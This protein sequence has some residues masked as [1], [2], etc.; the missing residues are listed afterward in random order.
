MIIVTN[1]YLCADVMLTSYD[2]VLLKPV[3]KSR[4]SESYIKLPPKRKVVSLKV[5]EK[6][7]KPVRKK[8]LRKLPVSCPKC[9]KLFV[10]ED[11][12]ERPLRVACK[13]CDARGIIS[14]VPPPSSPP[15][16]S[17][18][19]PGEPRSTIKLSCPDCE[20]IFEV[21]SSTIENI[22]CPRCGALGNVKKPSVA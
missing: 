1:Q 14:T 17:M 10:H 2:Y 15:L 16:L 12:G 5:G 21:S 7:K 20:N 8:K 6:L 22:E 3:P 13:Y 11:T 9:K 19:E 4:N 18:Q